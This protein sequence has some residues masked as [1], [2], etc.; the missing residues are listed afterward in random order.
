MERK[1]EISIIIPCLNEEKYIRACLDSVVASDFESLSF[2]I[3][4]VDGLSIDTTRQ[5]VQEYMQTYSNIVLLDN[6]HKLAPYAMNIGINRA[7][8][9][10]LFVVSAHA[11]YPKTYFR[12][13]ME[14]CIS[15]DADCVGPVLITDTRT[16]TKI[17]KAVKNVLSHKFGVG[18]S[19]RSGVE[20]VTKVDTVPFGCYKKEIFDKVGLYNEKLT[21]NQDI[22]LNKRII[23]QGGAIYLVPDVACTYYARETLSALAKNNFENGRW[24]ILTAFYTKTFKSLSLRHFV[25]LFFVLSLIVPMVLSLIESRLLWISLVSLCSYLALVIIISYKLSRKDKNFWQTV[26]TFF[27]LHISYGMGSLKGIIDVLI[28][29]LRKE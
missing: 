23:N 27:V 16:D 6:P 18:S 20:K 10:Y 2:E 25:P 26:M 15:L 21:R 11:K 19:F 8:G 7:K 29:S 28:L 4:I 14:Y 13:L 1:I 5:I 9:A 12:S 3:L 22:E 24:N 17:S